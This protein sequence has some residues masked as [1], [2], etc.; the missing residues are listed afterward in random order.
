MSPKRSKLVTFQVH[1]VL[2]RISLIHLLW[3]VESGQ[4]VLRVLPGTMTKCECNASR[5]VRFGYLL[6][7]FT[8]RSKVE[9]E[10]T[11]R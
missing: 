9:F 11:K 3:P 2:M 6:Y 5:E 7:R 1:V 8:R 4:E 10:W